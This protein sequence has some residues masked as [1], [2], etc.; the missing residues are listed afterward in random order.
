M[1]GETDRGKEGEEDVVWG[2]LLAK[3]VV[4]RSLLS[5]QGTGYQTESSLN[6][7]QD[8]VPQYMVTGY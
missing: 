7:A 6:P 3:V 2:C 1:Q 5:L 8:E 4:L